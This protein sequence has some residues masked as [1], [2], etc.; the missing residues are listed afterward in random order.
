MIEQTSLA[1]RL[2]HAFATPSQGILGLVEELLIASIEQE[3]R[4][5]WQAGCCY[6]NIDADPSERIEVAVQKSVIRAVLARIAVLCNE[7]VPNSV[8][9]YGGRGELTI[10]TNHAQVIRVNFINTLEEQSLELTPARFKEIQ[11]VGPRVSA[12]I[13]SV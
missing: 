10:D 4:L 6:L 5:E 11:Q 3:I 7:K 9:P 13:T 2:S 12:V 8:T 1:E